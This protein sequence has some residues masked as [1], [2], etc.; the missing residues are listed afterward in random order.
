MEEMKLHP[1]DKLDS[2]RFRLDI[3]TMALVGLNNPDHAHPLD[4]LA[5]LNWFAAGIASDMTETLLAMEVAEERK[6]RDQQ[7]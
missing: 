2:C 4:A 3:L 1:L 6:A 7:E 5:S